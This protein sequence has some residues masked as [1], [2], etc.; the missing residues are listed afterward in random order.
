MQSFCQSGE[1]SLTGKIRGA[2]IS[3]AIYYGS[4]LAIFGFLLIY[5]AIEHNIDGYQNKILIL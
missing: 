3:N 5:V 4:Y 1:F 2:L